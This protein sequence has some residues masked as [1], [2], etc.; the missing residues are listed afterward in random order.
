MPGRGLGGAAPR[1]C[2]DS[3]T[4]TASWDG[5]SARWARALPRSLGPLD[6]IEV[7]AGGGHLAAAI[8]DAAGWWARRWI[9]YHIVEIS[10]RLRSGPSRGCWRA[11][12]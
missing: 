2:H 9:R 11:G 10:P 6:L 1:F 12:R 5:P 7:G 8:L 4:F 3:L